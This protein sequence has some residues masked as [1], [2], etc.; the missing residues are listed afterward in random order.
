MAF[1][2]DSRVKIPAILHLTRLGYEYIPKYKHTDVN[3]NNIFVEVFKDSI[4][5]IN[6]EITDDELNDFLQEIEL[7]LDYDDLGESFYKILTV[8]TKWKLIDFE[9]ITNNKFHITTELTCKNGDEE[10]RPD[11]TI[12]ING[13][14]LSFIEVKKPNNKEG[15]IA[16]RKRINTR[17]QNKKFR[18]F[19][20]ITQLMV[21]SNNMEY[22]EETIDTIQGAYYATSSYNEP[23][24][25][26][27]REEEVF[28][29]HHLLNNLNEELENSILKDNNLSVIKHSKEYELN[30][31]YNT[32][33]NR[34]ITSLYSKQRF[35][36]ILKYALV[37][38]HKTNEDGKPNIEK[39]IM[40]YPQIFATKAIA[41]K[42]K[43]GNKR[44]IIWHTQGSGKT[45]L[46]YYNV[47]HLQDYFQ[48][49]NT[50]PKFYFIVDRL[51]LLKQAKTEFINRGLSVNIVNSKQEF[52]SDIKKASALHNSSGNNEITVVNIQKF[53]EESSSE[54][55]NDYDI[56]I[57]RVYFLDE[58]HRSYNPKGSFLAN[59]INS[60]KNAIII[61]LTGTP[62]ITK[63][64]YS[65]DLF[66][67]YIHKYYYNMSIADGYTLKL[68]REGIDTSYKMQMKEI[69][70]EIEILKGDLNKKDVFAHPKFARPM[71]DYILNDFKNSRVKFGE[72][73]GAMVVCD[74]SEQAKEMFGYFQELYGEQKTDYRVVAE[75]REP[76]GNR[77]NNEIR[78]ALILHDINDKDT[79]GNQVEDFKKGQ[80]DI[81]FVY[82][83]LLTGFDASRL[84]KL[85][86]GRI[87]KDHNLL[88]TLTRVNRPYK[89]FRY[90]FVVD[91]ADIRSAFDKTNKAYFDELQKDFGEDEMQHYRNLFKSEE[92]IEQE[93]QDI[94]ETLFS[95][96]TLNAEI[97]QQQI[98][99][100][101]SREEMLKIVKALRNAKELNNLIRFYGFED[102]LEKIDFFK[103]GQLLREAQAHLDNLNFRDQL[104][105]SADTTNL[106][107]V[108]L[109]DIIFMFRKVSE[110]ELILADQ[111]KNQLRL[112][113][114]AL[115]HNFDTK[116]P[117][118][119]S[120]KEELERMFKN[121]NLDEISQ[122]EMRENI[123]MLH[124][125]YEKVKELNRKNELLSAKYE[126]DEK[127]AR[128]HKRLMEKKIS[129]SEIN[130]YEALK[131]VKK[132]TDE[133]LLNNNNLLYNESF[134]EK[135]ITKLVM[136]EF[137][138]NKKI[139]AD[140][141]TTKYIG[142]LITNEYLT[143]LR[144]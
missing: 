125:V 65:K 74:S 140:A 102:L 115:L 86:L 61:G 137:V 35:L 62:L 15:I 71:L 79:R 77:N 44:G 142:N 36:F 59:L 70:D 75:E 29:Y 118:F 98:S 21:F 128:I 85:Y 97:F 26:F 24:F 144:G 87:V 14:P 134:F 101:Q 131:E 106:L 38:V 33:T 13:L 130:V 113:R 132:Q 23:I 49:E 109:E 124:Q 80:I 34:I 136:Q 120:L 2:E 20:N 82:N 31:S 40:R 139:I 90:G 78:G 119:I 127:Y 63:N 47:K 138:K 129:K 103:L 84:K 51:D 126:Q 107:N 32:P 16:E 94:K 46:A 68:I 111:L 99:Q 28:D 22:D 104:E 5:K 54:A 43:E 69:L 57:Q 117:Q 143:A 64:L 18:R 27:F 133:D 6:P 11:I 116:D 50:I 3:T 25:N 1:N 56:N 135:Y 89:K 12:F 37:Y 60:D 66:G 91:F 123:F 8:P 93:L 95:F 96:N 73:I 108:A 114:E 41:Q 88:Q 30:K 45:A 100:I 67:D 72:D 105:N 52:V 81:L 122:E 112:T 55:I 19:V 9:K 92:E 58:V 53:S 110:E 48:K 17:F 76:Y 7:K 42:I 141:P 39:H 83:M 10:F 4:K 121:K